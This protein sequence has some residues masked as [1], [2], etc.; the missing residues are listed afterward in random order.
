MMGGMPS[1][2][3]VAA[4]LALSTSL[5]IAPAAHGAVVTGG[6]VDWGV[7]QSFRTYVTSPIASGSIT[8]SEGASTNPGGTYRFPITGGDQPEAQR[9]SV[10]TRGKVRFSGHLGSLD[11][12]IFNVRVVLDGT[13][14]GP[15]L[16]ADADTKKLNG[17][18]VVESY[19]D[20]RFAKLDTTGLAPS[21][22]GGAT[23]WAGVPATLTQEG[24]PAFAGFY[25]PGEEL[26]PVTFSYSTGAG[27]GSAAGAC[28]KRGS[29]VTVPPGGTPPASKPA[30]AT[31]KLGKPTKG[32]LRLLAAGKAVSTKV[33]VS[34]AGKVT[35]TAQ[36]RIARKTRTAAKVSRRASK[37]GVVTLRWKISKSARRELVEEEEA[38]AQAHRR[39]ARCGQALG[40]ELHAQGAEGEGREQAL[41][42]LRR[43]RLQV[44]QPAL[45]L[46]PA[47]V[48]HE[49]AAGADHAV[50]G[51]HDRDRVAAVGGAHRAR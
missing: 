46:Q 18:G 27:T 40:P 2:R 51:H 34:Q 1:P 31:L 8:P 36:G 22:A 17:G 11:F 43:A 24:S 15:C 9:V 50:A 37:P 48:A 20:V 19:R 39:A 30:G 42:Q 10:G 47:A 28:E 12:T 29:V 35:L 5:L 49:L 16:V 6:N 45:G 23:T 33:R 13:A 26:D 21:T 4:V 44:Q 25:D 32:Q 3:S 41:E 38:Q 7:K 14:S